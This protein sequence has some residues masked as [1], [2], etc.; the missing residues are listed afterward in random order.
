MTAKGAVAKTLKKAKE[1]VD[2]TKPD[3]TEEGTSSAAASA[4]PAPAA[5]VEA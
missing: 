2:V 3:G 1:G 4:A 5:S